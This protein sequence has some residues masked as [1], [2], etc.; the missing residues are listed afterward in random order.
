MQKNMYQIK[1]TGQAKKELKNIKKIYEDA[2]N[3]A[4]EEIRENPFI[5]KPLTRELYGKYAYKL[6]TYR[7]IYKVNK[8]DKVVNILTA[9]HRGTIYE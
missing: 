5:G 7:I 4:L 9:G 8:K 1:L 6:D 2:I 3:S